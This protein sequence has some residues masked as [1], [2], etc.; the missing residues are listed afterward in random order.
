MHTAKSIELH[1][2]AIA[3]GK[4]ALIC[5]PLVGRTLD[6][7]M[8]ELA[9]VLPKQPDVLEWR[10]DHFEAIGDTA[11]VIAAAR[12]IKQAAGG[13]PVLFTRRSTLEGGE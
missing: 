1:G 12:A 11:A 3:G 6:K 7:L 5:V 10:V 8:T 13:I 9:V 4:I 2:R